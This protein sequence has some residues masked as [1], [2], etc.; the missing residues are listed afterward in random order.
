MKV[1]KG[2]IFSCVFTA[3]LGWFLSNYF[4]QRFLLED[5]FS[6]VIPTLPETIEVAYACLP[7]IL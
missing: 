5:Q 3:F 4:L 7:G 1:D 2:L 6:N